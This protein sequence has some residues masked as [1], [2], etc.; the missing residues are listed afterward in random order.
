MPSRPTLS[1]FVPDNGVVRMDLRRIAFPH[2]TLEVQRRKDTH[3]HTHTHTHTQTHT[4]TTKRGAV[5]LY[6]SITLPTTL[7]RSLSIHFVSSGSSC[8][9]FS[10]TGPILRLTFS[11]LPPVSFFRCIYFPR[12]PLGSS[13]R[14][15]SSLSLSLS[16][17]HIPTS[18]SEKRGLL[19]PVPVGTASMLLDLHLSASAMQNT[20]T[21]AQF[22]PFTTTRPYSTRGG[23]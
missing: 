9:P 23:R 21:H 14:P 17:S 11:L 12:P 7:R 6:R 5:L 22:H 20:I 18:P 13:A 1:S 2:V 3:T 16:V 10:S 15:S 19:S 8:A 4:H